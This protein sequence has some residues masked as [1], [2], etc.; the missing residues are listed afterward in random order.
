M[1]PASRRR[2]LVLYVLVAAMLAALGGRLWYLQALNGPQFRALAVQNQTRDIVVPAV[3]GEILDDGRPLVTNQ[4]ALVVVSVN[5]MELSQQSDGGAAVLHRL[6]RL[7]GMSYNQLKA[8]T[9]LCTRGVKQPCW[10]GSPTSRS[11]SMSMS[12]TRTC[13]KSWKSPSL[14]PDVTAQVQP[15]VYY[16][17]S[18]WREPGAG[19]RLP[20]ADHVAGDGAAA[21]HGHRLLRR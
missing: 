20:A 21:P 1:I 13:C 2:L 10:T 4:T 7:L 8:K 14:Y 18:G 12:A 5:M 11:R 15:V 3:R 16:P 17:S 6:A 9:T 19:P